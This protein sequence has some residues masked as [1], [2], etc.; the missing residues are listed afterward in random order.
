M[1]EVP[2]PLV[3]CDQTFHAAAA[4]KIGRG[5]PTREHKFQRAQ[6]RIR[7]LEIAD[8]ARVM[9][10]HE[11]LVRESPPLPRRRTGTVTNGT[12]FR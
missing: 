6:K 11:N 5:R 1:S 7:N 8:V 12:L 9:K 3:G 10:C 2:K 4:A